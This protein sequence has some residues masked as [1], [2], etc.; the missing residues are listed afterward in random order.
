MPITTTPMRAHHRLL[1]PY[2]SAPLFQ[3]EGDVAATIEQLRKIGVADA[4]KDFL[5]ITL[6]HYR[7]VPPTSFVCEPEGREGPLGGPADA[8]YSC[9]ILSE[10]GGIRTP[11][12][13]DGKLWVN[14][15]GWSKGNTTFVMDCYPLIPAAEYQGFVPPWHFK[16]PPLPAYLVLHT[17]QRVNYRG[18]PYV[19]GWE[20]MHLYT[21]NALEFPENLPPD[22]E[23]DQI[24][25][26]EVSSM[27]EA[28]GYGVIE[29][30]DGSIRKEI[31]ALALS[32]QDL[33]GA[34]R[35][36]RAPILFRIAGRLWLGS[37]EPERSRWH[38]SGEWDHYKLTE[39]V[40]PEQLPPGIT[41]T[42]YPEGFGYGL[43]EGRLITNRGQTYAIG[44]PHLYIGV[45]KPRHPR[46][47]DQVLQL[48]PD[49]SRC[50]HL[51]LEVR[52]LDGQDRDYELE[53]P[54]DYP[55]AICRCTAR[56]LCRYQIEMEASK[57]GTATAATACAGYEPIFIDQ[58]H[59]IIDAAPQRTLWW[60]GQPPSQPQPA[61][62]TT[63]EALAFASALLIPT[64]VRDLHRI[65]PKKAVAAARRAIRD[66]VKASAHPIA[67]AIRLSGGNVCIWLPA[68]HGK[69]NPDLELEV[70]E[71][72]TQAMPA[73]V[74]QTRLI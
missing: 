52:R 2:S 61:K 42:A 56:S 51:V 37:S 30:A 13:Y 38:R 34:L 60:P 62:P 71:F 50:P 1:L 18:K 63:K 21:P 23:E 68:R 35:M 8:S 36:N 45:W 31:A 26:L 3:R 24:I 19:F 67:P 47:P 39:V 16:D 6:L 73:R 10:N 5:G 57:Y 72:I 55:E 69:G 40:A 70:D 54:P 65:D 4:Q 41:P 64:E 46:R 29:D 12:R 9:D 20:V 14:T 59:S 53:G 43:E 17:G 27:A 32:Y 15:G 49:S 44:V 22:E 25:G 33:R 74:V 7:L 58:A 11:F 48:S 28:F 66:R